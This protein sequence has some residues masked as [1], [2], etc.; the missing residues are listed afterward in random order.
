[1]EFKNKKRLELLKEELE[2]SCDKFKELICSDL[3]DI[4]SGC[5]ALVTRDK[6]ESCIEGV[7]VTMDYCPFCGKEIKSEYNRE[8]GFW[9]WYHS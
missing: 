9:R 8:K 2:N 5:V 7:G 3:V 1:M 4:R 6:T